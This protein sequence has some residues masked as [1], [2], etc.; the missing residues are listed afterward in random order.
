MTRSIEDS[1]KKWEK[2]GYP[3][4]S[5]RKMTGDATIGDVVGDIIKRI[6]K[7]VSLGATGTN[8]RTDE[9]KG[10]ETNSETKKR[11]NEETKRGKGKRTK[12]IA[13]Y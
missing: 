4:N 9:R 10:G 11:R 6:G 1:I 3:P 5:T 13:G 2:Y 8:E 12:D 7:Q